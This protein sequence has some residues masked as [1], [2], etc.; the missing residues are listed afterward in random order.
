MEYANEMVVKSTAFGLR[1]TEIPTTLAPDGRG[2]APHLRTWRDGWRTL[3]FLLLYS[4]RWLFL[5]P[6]IVLFVLGTVASGILLPG[7]LM[8]GNVGFDVHTLLFAAM[9]I[10]IG[11]QSIVFAM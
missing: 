9:T 11:F 8:I 4:P 3:R 1:I 7:P 6:G 5:Y 10:L 2:R